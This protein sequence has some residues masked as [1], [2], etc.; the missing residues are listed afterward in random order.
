VKNSKIDKFSEFFFGM[1]KAHYHEKIENSLSPLFSNSR[2][3]IL[4]HRPLVFLS[5][6]V[7][8]AISVRIA[9]I[10]T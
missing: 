6:L 2:A 4:L 8:V 9:T 10:D 3:P 1:L 7:L 5:I